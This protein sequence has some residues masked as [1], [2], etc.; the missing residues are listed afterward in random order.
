[1]EKIEDL[2]FLKILGKGAYGQVFLT[3]KKNS[4]KLF[5]TKKINKFIAETEM[6]RYFK[7]EINILRILKHPNI[8]KFEEI[9]KDTNNYYIVMEYVNGGELSD[10]LKKYK[11]K[12]QK[13]FPEEVVQ[14][15]MRQIVG[16]LIYIHDLNIIH[17]DLKLENIMVNFDSEKDKEELNMMKAKVKIIDF[18]FAIILPSKF[19]LTNS[20]VGTFM[21]MDPKIIAEFN[22][23]ALV[24]KSRGYGKEAD[25]WS[26]GCICYELFRGKFPFEASTFDELVS[27]INQG[28]YKLPRTASLEIVS[29]LDK[30]LKYEGKDR[31]S[32]R[33]LSNQPFLVKNVKNF[34]YLHIKEDKR[35]SVNYSTPNKEENKSYI[36]HN[37][38]PAHPLKEESISNSN[39]SSSSYNMTNNFYGG[40]SLKFQ[41]M[42]LNP[43]PKM[44][45]QIIQ[46]P[47]NP[48]FFNT[49][50][51]VFNNTG[52]PYGSFPNQYYIQN[53]QKPAI[54]HNI[55]NNTY[56]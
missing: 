54:S 7:Y 33:E 52:I 10:Y 21:Y 30:M 19:S 3:K 14:H 49:S 40:M 20:A 5:A 43:Q 42:P 27:K 16:A 39:K 28:R 12:Y 48:L 31:L 36:K 23:Q 47:P 51:P 53:V 38:F 55:D 35:E 22:S 29:F 6:T 56:L 1:M 50:F 8:V 9:K 25:I 46:T 45:S 13:A 32:A 2:T 17:R 4:N 24:D 18:G 34:T 41:P 11:L 15:L 44:Q 37:S 26:L